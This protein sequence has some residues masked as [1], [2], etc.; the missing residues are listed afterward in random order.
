MNS[1]R[2]AVIFL[3]LL[4]TLISP[5]A[6]RADIAVGMSV[7]WL[8]ADSDVVAR[9][10]VLSITAEPVPSI[11]RRHRAELKVIDRFKGH[12]SA[13]FAILVDRS[14]AT[15]FQA[16]HKEGVR[17]ILFFNHTV[18]AEQSKDAAERDLARYPL[19]LAESWRLD[20]EHRGENKGKPYACT[21]DLRLI[22][23]PG[24]ID[25]AI[26]EAVAT[27]VP[28]QTPFLESFEPYERFHIPRTT[29]AGGPVYMNVN[30]EYGSDISRALFSRSAV[31]VRVPLDARLANLAFVWARMPT[32]R[33]EALFILRH[34]KSPESIA[35]MRDLLDD[36][37]HDDHGYGGPAVT[38]RHPIRERAWRT[39]TAWGIDTPRPAIDM[40]VEGYRDVPWVWTVALVLGGISAMAGLV[41]R[42]RLFIRRDLPV[43]AG[44]LVS[45]ADAVCLALVVLVI[46][47][48][49]LTWTSQTVVR[50]LTLTAAA[51]RYWAWIRNGSITV[52]RAEGWREHSPLRAGS[53]RANAAP[54]HRWGLPIPTTGGVSVRN[55]W[56]PFA[57]ASAP[58][59]T[60]FE[61]AVHSG[62]RQTVPYQAVTAPVWS[63]ATVLA[64]VPVTRGALMIRRYARLRRRRR[65]NQCLEC[66]YDLRGGHDRCPECGRPATGGAASVQSAA[67][68]EPGHTA[69]PRV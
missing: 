46:A 38:W 7:E 10:E 40:P 17:P 31:Y 23:D 59:T 54:H 35:L 41:R 49:Y 36:P 6:I 67:D 4:V 50:E 57:H 5:G 2:A 9:C 18:P 42:R 3:A 33:E 66:G 12:P 1:T 45:L 51:D 53:F 64:A 37:T 28:T 8:V 47:L 48:V 22:R 55:E 26:R 68:G 21:M 52:S 58:L 43:R 39:L 63:L 19:R 29:R 15:Q 11:H 13:R 14:A 69:R 25:A 34:F 24:Y 61:T 60:H 32:M 27:E 20:E 16:W 56:G 44:V 62:P 65:L 30:A